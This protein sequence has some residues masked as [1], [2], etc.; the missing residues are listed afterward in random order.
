VRDGEAGAADK[1]LPMV[2]ASLIYLLV[3]F[4]G[5][6]LTPGLVAEVSTVCHSPSQS[7]QAHSTARR[8]LI[9]HR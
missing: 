3:G 7:N 9:G 4:I 6:E 5:E 1:A 8:G 2:L